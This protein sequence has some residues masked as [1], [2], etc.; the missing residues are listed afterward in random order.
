MKIIEVLLSV[1]L[2]YALLSIMVSSIVEM[3]NNLQKSRGKMLHSAILQML[4]DP[5]NLQ[6]GYLLLKHPLIDSMN[7]QKEKRPFQYLASDAFADAFIDVIG[8]QA[9]TGLPI[10][11]NKKSDEGNDFMASRETSSDSAMELFK[12]GVQQMN[13]SPFKD[14]LLSFYSKSKAD[15]PELKKMI[16][17]WYNNFMD[18][19]TGWYKRKQGT[20][21]FLVGLLVA[22]VLN[23]DS[24]HLF[25][26]IYMDDNLRN[27]LTQ[28][29]EGVAADYSVEGK[30][31]QVLLKHQ[32]SVLDS[33]IQVLETVASDTTVHSSTIKTLLKGTKTLSENI[34]TSDSLRQK[35]VEQINSILIMTDELGFPVGWSKSEAPL[36]WFAKGDIPK[37]PNNKLG[38]Y[39]NNRND[40]LEFGSFFMYLIGIFLTGFLLSFGAPFWF[41]ILVKFVNIR[42]AGQKPQAGIISQKPTS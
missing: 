31:E 24:I 26:V 1:V 6:Y 22:C 39:L 18:R 23:V 33:N 2:I 35:Q 20:K 21:F 11:K 32:L 5:L 37:L 25:K 38:K 15:Y 41:D 30:D 27:N 42:K 19:T 34:S 8:H 10:L 13:N 16:E 14:M 28:V 7:N 29:A 40:N 12:K 3:L 9:E 17:N 36:S 4:N